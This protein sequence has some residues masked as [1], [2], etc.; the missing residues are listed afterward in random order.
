[1]LSYKHHN[2]TMSKHKDVYTWLAGFSGEMVIY[3]FLF[4]FLVIPVKKSDMSVK[5]KW[6]LNH[7]HHKHELQSPFA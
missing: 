7:T 5:Y 2:F 6:L 4:G 3:A 1:M